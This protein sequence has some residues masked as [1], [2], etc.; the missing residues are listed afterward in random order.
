[1]L[2]LSVSVSDLAKIKLG[3]CVTTGFSSVKPIKHLAEIMIIPE[4]HFTGSA[5]CEPRWYYC[6]HVKSYYSDDLG[7]FINIYIITGEVLNG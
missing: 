1:M 4:Y 5:L 6:R 3:Q 2:C 7:L